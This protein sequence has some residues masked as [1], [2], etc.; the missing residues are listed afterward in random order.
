MYPYNY[1][2]GQTIQTDVPSI[3]ADRGF[4]ANLTWTAEETAAADT[5]GIFDGIVA[6]DLTATPAGT[7]V[8]KTP[9]SDEFVAKNP[10]VP[11]VKVSESVSLNVTEPPL[12]ILMRSFDSVIK[13]KYAP[14]VPDDILFCLGNVPCAEP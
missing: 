13:T 7:T 6:G 1:K 3:V 4:I 9:A 12:F 8:T 11:I 5:D 10:F 14:E 2:Y